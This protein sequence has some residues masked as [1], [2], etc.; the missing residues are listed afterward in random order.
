MKVWMEKNGDGV[1]NKK[2]GRKGRKEGRKGRTEG[3]HEYMNEQAGRQV[4]R[5]HMLPSTQIQ[6]KSLLWG[7]QDG[8]M[9]G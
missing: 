7:R 8:C 2:R 5:K 6:V 3:R 4:Q 9:D 1:E